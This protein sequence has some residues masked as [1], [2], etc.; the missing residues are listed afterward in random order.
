MPKVPIVRN[1]DFVFINRFLMVIGFLIVVTLILFGASRFINR[2]IPHET[3]QGALQQLESRIAPIGAVYAGAT[4]AAAQAAAQALA[5]AAAVSQV[6]YGGTLDGGTIYQNL[7]TGCHGSGAGGAP[8][9]DHA[10]WDARIAQGI[11]TLYQHSLEGFTG[12]SGM[13]PAKGGNPALSEEQVRAAVDWMIGNL[14]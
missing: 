4:G 12:S 1:H 14:K 2:V 6:A 13:M 3:S 5:A 7:S 11:D 9:L 10:H 8:I